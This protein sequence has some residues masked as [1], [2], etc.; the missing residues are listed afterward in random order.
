MSPWLS[1]AVAVFTVT[2][3]VSGVPGLVVGLLAAVAVVLVL[4]SASTAA[5]VTRRER[6]A[7][8]LPL[9]VDLLV[10]CVGAGRPPGQSLAVVAEAVG[11]PLGEELRSTAGRLEL[12]ADPLAVWQDLANDA[13]FAPLGRS[14]A[15]SARTGSA[16]NVA[17]ARCADDLRRE[18]HAAADARARQVSVRASAP[19][20][21]CFLPAFF[22]VGVVPTIV[23]GL[24]SIS[25]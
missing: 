4:R 3:V 10:S 15:R 14:L 24:Q 20:G 8:D 23:G 11:G 25:W 21:V 18:R 9:A 17:L 12:G 2:R 7:A 16:V 13:V 5:Q 6:V 22:L 1:A 19:L